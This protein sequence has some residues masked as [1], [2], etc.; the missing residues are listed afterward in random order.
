MEL[1]E[2]TGKQFPKI[3][4]VWKNRYSQ[5]N[6]TRTARLCITKNT[7]Q[8]EFFFANKKWIIELQILVLDQLRTRL[9]ANAMEYTT[10]KSN[11]P[12]NIGNQRHVYLHLGVSVQNPV[13]IQNFFLSF[14]QTKKIWTPNSEEWTTD[15]MIDK[16]SKK[17]KKITIEWPKMPNERKKQSH[18][19]TN[20]CNPTFNENC[21]ILFT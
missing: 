21:N 18:T 16:V 6:V 1:P 8:Y 13:Q 10:W 20:T 3:I 12:K 19:R 15:E 4:P 17:R 2:A 9:I 7:I 14:A 5:R 11:G